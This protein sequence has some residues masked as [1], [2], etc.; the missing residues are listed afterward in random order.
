M[1]LGYCAHI[2]YR[3]REESPSG[4]EG[5]RAI[6]DQ[7]KTQPSCCYSSDFLILFL[8]VSTV[9]LYCL[10]RGSIIITGFLSM[11]GKSF[12]YK[13]SKHHWPL[14]HLS[15]SASPF[16]NRS[17]PGKSSF[18]NETNGSGYYCV[19]LETISPGRKIF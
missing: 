15:C 10:S 4:W 5:N 13:P 17:R 12:S 9:G 18:T 3:E 1:S 8:A 14:S 2:L 7:Y 6:G 16:E 19:R 11:K